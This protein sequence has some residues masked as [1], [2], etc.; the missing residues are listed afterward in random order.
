[1]IGFGASHAGSKRPNNE[2]AFIV[3]NE[4]RLF[5]VC[6][7]L[8][9]HACGEKASHLAVETLAKE[10]A[11]WRR[12]RRE[13]GSLEDVTSE[14]L[15]EVSHAVQTVCH[16]VYSC[17][18]EDTSCTGM[19]TTLTMVLFVGLKAVMAHVGDPRLYLVRGG[20]IEQLSTDHTMCEEL[21]R[22]GAL[23]P[24]QARKSQF[25]NVLTRNIGTD[26]SVEV[27]IFVIDVHYGDRFLLCSD[28][29][30]EYFEEKEGL[31]PYFKGDSP[32]AISELIQ[33]ANRRGGKDNITA[34]AIEVDMD[35]C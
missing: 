29:L 30:S 22:S 31:L 11:Q 9:G 4:N 33:E 20:E 28:G 26:P 15:E 23:T 3:D 13:T 8:G 7:G 12:R 21:V 5:V 2:D 14:D 1:M 24:E 25:A 19:G 17:A 27:D 10:I 35:S 6:D 18:T 34:L 16:E 32:T